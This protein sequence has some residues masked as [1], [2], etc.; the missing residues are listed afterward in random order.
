MTNDKFE[1]RFKYVESK[2]MDNNGGW[3]LF[4]SE[5]LDVF[6]HESKKLYK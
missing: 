2:V 4:S 1:K 6:W 5:D 3:G